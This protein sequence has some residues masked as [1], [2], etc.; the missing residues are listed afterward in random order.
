MAQARATVSVDDEQ[1][2]VTT[3]TFDGAGVAIGQHRH[4]FDYVV[5]PV[6]GGTFTVIDP[7]GS[8]REMNQVAGSPYLGTAGTAHDVVNA[9]D[10]AAVFVEIE[11]KR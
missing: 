11:L 6:T 3:W 8:E 10:L 1:V 2:R 4:E 7:D 9:T 5:V